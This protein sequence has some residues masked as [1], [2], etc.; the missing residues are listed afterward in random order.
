MDGRVNYPY[1]N[2]YPLIKVPYYNTFINVPSNYNIYLDTYYGN[3]WKEYGYP[4]SN[5]FFMKKR[6]I[7]YNDPY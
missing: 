1:K 5:G 7:I 2:F 4:S 3:D 6:K